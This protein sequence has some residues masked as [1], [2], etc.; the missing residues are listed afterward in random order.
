M[1]LILT[2]ELRDLLLGEKHKEFNERAQA[3]APD[4]ARHDLRA[5]DLRG[6]VL[7]RAD[8]RDAYLRNADLRGVDLSAARL[9]GASLRDAKLSGALFPRELRAEEIRLSFEVGTRL[10]PHP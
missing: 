1:D 7:S 4:L 10:R 6:F 5:L 9:E 8:L 3:D 2:S